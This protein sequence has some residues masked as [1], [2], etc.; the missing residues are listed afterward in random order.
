M[1]R[2]GKDGHLGG[3]SYDFDVYLCVLARMQPYWTLDIE[4]R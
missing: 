4:R 2:P 3:G 1:L